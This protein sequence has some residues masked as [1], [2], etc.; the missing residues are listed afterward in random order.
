VAAAQPP[1][2]PN[3]AAA[4]SPAPANNVNAD[5][6]LIAAK[7]NF[8]TK[9]LAE[10]AGVNPKV[11]HYGTEPGPPKVYHLYASFKKNGVDISRVNDDAYMMT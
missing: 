9:I 10:F 8:T 5:A 3:I 1:A 7:A 11:V 2:Q 6:D 4:A